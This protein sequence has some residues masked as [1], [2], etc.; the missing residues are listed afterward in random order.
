ME[1][2]E[3]AEAQKQSASARTDDDATVSRQNGVSDAAGETS[4]EPLA[5][6]NLKSEIRPPF[7]NLVDR[8]A[9]TNSPPG[10]EAPEPTAESISA[11]GESTEPSPSPE[12]IASAVTQAVESP[13]GREEAATMMEQLDPETRTA[14][15]QALGTKG[16]DS[17]FWKYAASG[18][19]DEAFIK[20]NVTSMGQEELE[21][22]R[23]Y[24]EYARL[25]AWE[26][27]LLSSKCSCT[28]PSSIFIASHPFQS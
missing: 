24:R 23:E 12:E 4:D 8:H 14:V 1:I 20:D 15:E 7:E 3:S 13:E 2:E 27:P 16:V 28:G 18:P 25:A 21:R 9:R 17:G 19:S 26:L 10:T 6:S 11:E 22:Q 5:T